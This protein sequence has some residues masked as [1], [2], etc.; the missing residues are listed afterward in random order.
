MDSYLYND[1]SLS[2]KGGIAQFGEYSTTSSSKGIKSNKSKN[3]D[4]TIEGLESTYMPSFGDISSGGEILDTDVFQTTGINYNSNKDGFETQYKTSNNEFQNTF[5]NTTPFVDNWANLGDFQSNTKGGNSEFDLQIGSSFDNFSTQFG[6]YQSTTNFKNEYKSSETNTDNNFNL[7]TF[8]TTTK[9]EKNTS[10]IKNDYL[11]SLSPIIDEYPNFNFGEYQTT[12]SKKVSTAFN[13]EFS[14]TTSLMDTNVNVDTN[15]YETSGSIIDNV[16]TFDDNFYKGLQTTVDTTSTIDTTSFTKSSPVFE[17]TPKSNLDI[18][19]TSVFDLTQN[20]NTETFTSTNTST[21][22]E[23]NQKYDASAYST[24][25]SS[26]K[27]DS[28]NFTKTSDFVDNI[29]TYDDNTFATTE[30][31]LGT[32]KKKDNISYS[33]TEINKTP[34]FDTTEYTTTII[35]DSTTSFKENTPTSALQ[36]FDITDY[37]TSLDFTTSPIVDTN[38]EL[39]SKP[40]KDTTTYEI[41]SPLLDLGYDFTNLKSAQTYDSGFNEYQTTN[42]ESTV[43]KSTTT[44]KPKLFPNKEIKQTTSLPMETNSVLNT[45]FSLGTTEITPTSYT[46]E[47]YGDYTTTTSYDKI[48]STS[49]SID[50]LLLFNPSVPVSTPQSVSISETIEFPTLTTSV[51]ISNNSKNDPINIQTP[52]NSST[53]ETSATFGEYISS[54]AKGIKSGH[55]PDLGS[56]IRVSLPSE[57]ITIKVPK[58]KK[59]IIPKIKKIYIPSTQKIY[60]KKPS[61]SSSYIIEE[62]PTYA[63]NI[64][65]VSNPDTDLSIK[66]N[67]TTII[68]LPNPKPSISIVPNPIVKTPPSISIVPNPETK[69]SSYIS[70]IP[71]PIIKTPPSISIVPNPIK[72]SSSSISIVPNPLKNS[73]SSSISIVP[74]PIIKSS[75][76]ISI[77]PNPVTKAITTNMPIESTNPQPVLSTISTL[78]ME[79]VVSTQI[80]PY[81]VP[82]VNIPIISLSPQPFLNKHKTKTGVKSIN[83][84]VYGASTYKPISRHLS[85]DRNLAGSRNII[86]LKHRLYPN[87]TYTARKL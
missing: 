69:N 78:P 74:N 13:P 62:N 8:G 57:K 80:L 64:S 48:E 84:A 79:S 26:P 2:Q 72:K 41:N 47:I 21:S 25:E 29:F 73:S 55:T 38:S 77:V 43:S 24:T 53:L 7:D 11:T 6:D 82:K 27:Y 71:N 32:N 58:I 49:P 60:I 14:T 83:P 46:N 23:K 51:D 68:D 35:N 5:E 67:T 54:K 1:I 10:M 86:N 37:Q 4:F 3:Q 44:Q 20:I 59:V 52:R 50:D 31:I 39:L 63:N 19:G 42:I 33:N 15:T 36:T 75:S 61:T 40:K 76:S 16:D 45:G 70:I 28:S 18:I 17:T 30:Q 87:R 85:T 34:S 81:Q 12:E 66:K 9:N 22:Y 56:P 65:Y